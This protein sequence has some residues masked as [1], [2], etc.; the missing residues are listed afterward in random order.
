MKLVRGNEVISLLTES[1]REQRFSF[2]LTNLKV[3]IHE[4]DHLKTPIPLRLSVF[5]IECSSLSNR[6]V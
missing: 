1:L 3:N 6:V 4:Q 2:H 5:E